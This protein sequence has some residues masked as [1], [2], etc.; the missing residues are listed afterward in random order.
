M[1]FSNVLPRFLWIT[2][3]KSY[4]VFL[5]GIAMIGIDFLIVINSLIWQPY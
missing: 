4:D 2:V 5:R 3:Y 1:R